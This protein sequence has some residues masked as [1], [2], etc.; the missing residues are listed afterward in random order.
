MWKKI[1]IIIVKFAT[2]IVTRVQLLTEIVH[3]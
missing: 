2:D 1:N 3:F